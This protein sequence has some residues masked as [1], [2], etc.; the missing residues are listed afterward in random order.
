MEFYRYNG[1]LRRSSGASYPSPVTWSSRFKQATVRRI[2]RGYHAIVEKMSGIEVH[3]GL[4][5]IF[6]ANAVWHSIPFSF[7][8]VRYRNCSAYQV[9]IHQVIEADDKMT[10]H[11]RT[12]RGSLSFFYLTKRFPFILF[13]HRPWIILLLTTSRCLEFTR[14]FLNHHSPDRPW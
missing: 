2:F 14:P 3:L 9:T 11:V 13:S 8:H 1:M 6:F 4:S 5:S 12:H 10:V 7:S